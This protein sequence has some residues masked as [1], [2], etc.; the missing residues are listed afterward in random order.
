MIRPG[1]QYRN[2]HSHSYNSWRKQQQHRFQHLGCRGRAHSDGDH[3]DFSAY[4]Y[5]CERN[6]NRYEFCERRHNCTGFRFWSYSGVSSGN[7][8]HFADGLINDQ[9]RR[10]YRKSNSDVTTSAGSSNGITFTITAPSTNQTQTQRLFGTW[11]FSYT[12]GTAPFSDTYRRNDVEASTTTSGE[13]VIYGKNEFNG[14]VVA[15]YAPTLDEFVLYDP[16][17]R[18]RYGRCG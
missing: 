14:L 7:E 10:E 5:D 18:S 4:R 6:T 8:S 17:T 1:R 11:L 16:G 13:W 2:S 9:H 12:I 3:S 15:Q